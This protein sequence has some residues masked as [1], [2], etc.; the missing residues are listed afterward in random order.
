MIIGVAGKARAGKDTTADMLCKILRGSKMSFATPIKDGLEAMFGLGP[1]Y[2][3]GE[4]KEHP[5]HWLGN[6]STR[7]L[8]Q[9]LGTEWGRDMVSSSIWIDIGIRRAKH[10]LVSKPK[11]NAVVFADVRFDNEAIAIRDAGGVVLEVQRPYIDIGSEHLT[12]TGIDPELVDLTI[13]N[14]GDLGDLRKTLFQIE[15]TLMSG[16]RSWLRG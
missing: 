9:T 3:H 10:R 8:M 5:I 13:C 11:I 15:L 1:E 14:D 12:E 16:N 7:Y 4:L 2:L 6:K